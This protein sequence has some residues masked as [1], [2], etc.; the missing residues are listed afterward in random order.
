[1]YEHTGTRKKADDALYDKIDLDTEEEEAHNLLTAHEK[2][3]QGN[4]CVC[5]NYFISYLLDSF[6]RNQI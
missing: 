2:I 6:L 5:I 3:L 1:M 4:L